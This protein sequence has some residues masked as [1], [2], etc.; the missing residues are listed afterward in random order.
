MNKAELT[1]RVVVVGL[2]SFNIH[3]AYQAR[4]EAD[5]ASNY[6]YLAFNS[7]EDASRHAEEAAQ[8]AEQANLSASYCVR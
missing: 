8:Q 5:N 3:M 2:L 1:F 4:E 6:A 7:A